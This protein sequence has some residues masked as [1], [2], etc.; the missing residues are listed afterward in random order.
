[1]SPDFDTLVRPHKDAVYRQLLR[2]CGNHEDAED[3]LVE[4]MLKAYRALPSLRDEDV[5]RAWLVQIGRRT[6]GRLKKR[7]AARPVMGLDR[8]SE[9]GIEISDDDTGPE[10]E[11]LEAET[12]KCVL[13]AF[14]QL[15]EIYREAYRL[16]EIEG[17][18]GEE[19]AAQLGITL[20]ALKSR[21][22]RARAELRA[23]LEPSFSELNG[24]AG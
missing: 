2:M 3:V 10:Q 18:T 17:L 23:M 11:V 14:E 24:L 21:L 15:P 5:F 19:A 6:C 8:L 7:D 13:A 20:P 22:H 4:S 1:M 16:R 12:K 9:L